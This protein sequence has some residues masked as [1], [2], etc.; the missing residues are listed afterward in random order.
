MSW[1]ECAEPRCNQAGT[2]EAIETTIVPRVRDLGGF[3]VRRVLP[4]SQR[5]MVGPLIFFDQMGPA[6]LAAGEGMHVRLIAG[7][8]LG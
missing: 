3:E 7:S 4:A 1:I 8:L 6:E 2:L 5:Q